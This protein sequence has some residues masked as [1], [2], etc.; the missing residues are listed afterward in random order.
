[1]NWVFIVLSLF[2][3]IVQPVVEQGVQR[4][5]AQYQQTSQPV[6]RHDGQR[7][8]KYERGQWYYEVKKDDGAN[9]S[10]LAVRGGVRKDPPAYEIGAREVGR[11][12]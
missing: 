7:W 3:P 8:W 4:M 5:Q 6:Y 11:A 2:W 10:G 1:M 12:W 9:A